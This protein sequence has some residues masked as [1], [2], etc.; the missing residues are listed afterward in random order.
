MKSMTR[1]KPK[2]PNQLLPLPRDMK[3]WLPKD[4]LVYFIIDVFHILNLSAICDGYGRSRAGQPPYD[5]K[6]MT[7]LTLPAKSRRQLYLYT[8]II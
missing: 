4:D 6:M 5:P 3:P 2:C 8:I 7:W 1:I